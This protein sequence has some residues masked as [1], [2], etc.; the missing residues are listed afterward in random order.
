M[1]Q[2]ALTWN[3]RMQLAEPVFKEVRLA[4]KETLRLLS[5]VEATPETR[6]HLEQARID[7]D[8]LERGLR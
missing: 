4:L 5:A 7:V 1:R 8:A 3:Q 2:E 6:R